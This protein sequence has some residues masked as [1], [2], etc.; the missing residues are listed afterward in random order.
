[1]YIR[2]KGKRGVALA[3]P[4]QAFLDVVGNV[5]GKERLANVGI[6]I[7]DAGSAAIQPAL[8]QIVTVKNGLQRVRLFDL[9]DNADD[10]RRGLRM[11]VLD[12][13]ARHTRTPR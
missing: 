5:D 1:M 4:F 10:S 11:K 12:V 6:P 2:G 9:V 13:P 8:D 3:R 7:D